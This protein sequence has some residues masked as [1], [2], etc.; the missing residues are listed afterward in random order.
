M[1]D[2]NPFPK[3]YEGVL[4]KEA[5]L[6]VMFIGNSITI[7]EIRP[8]LGWNRLCGM[9]KQSTRRRISFISTST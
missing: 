1:V 8:E 6:K 3:Y 7:H 5:K 9:Y 2:K 4:P